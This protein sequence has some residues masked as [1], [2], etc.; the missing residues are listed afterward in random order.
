MKRVIKIKESQL[1]SLIQRVLNESMIE[2]YESG[3]EHTVYR[4]F[5]SDSE[6]NLQN[7]ANEVEQWAFN[8]TENIYEANCEDGVNNDNYE[9]EIS[10]PNGF[11]LF[12]TGKVEYNYSYFRGSYDEPPDADMEVYYS[13]VTDFSISDNNLDEIEIPNKE[14]IL[15]QVFDKMKQYYKF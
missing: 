5:K 1:K 9:I 4:S 3:G 12:M 7:I 10:Y 8:M 11:S 13:E 15:Q 2:R 6:F 14:K